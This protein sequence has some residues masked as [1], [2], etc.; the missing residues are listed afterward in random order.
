MKRRG[1]LPF[2]V[3]PVFASFRSPTVAPPARL[4][5]CSRRVLFLGIGASGMV[6]RRAA[7]RLLSLGL[8]AIAIEDPYTQ[9]FAT[10]N[11]GSQDVVVRISHTGQTAAI[12]EA[13]R[14]AR[15]RGARTVALTNYLQ[16][17]LAKGG[18]PQSDH[19]LPRASH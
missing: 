8:S 4:M 17:P 9:I 6:A 7:Q 14:R 15:R 3:S 2:M 5:Q 12:T 11:V 1:F 16:S 10:E 18:W 19:G 13:I